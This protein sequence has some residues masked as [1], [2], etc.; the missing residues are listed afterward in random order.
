[1]DELKRDRK[2]CCQKRDAWPKRPTDFRP[3][4]TLDVEMAVNFPSEAEFPYPSIA[5]LPTEDEAVIQ[6]ITAYH[7]WNE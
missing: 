1:V 3:F 6:A 5:Y 2:E 7:E 4:G